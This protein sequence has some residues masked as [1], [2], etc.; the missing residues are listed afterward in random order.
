MKSFLMKNLILFLGC[1]LALSAWSKR[2]EWNGEYMHGGE[3]APVQ[4]LH[5]PVV[6]AGNEDGRQLIAKYRSDG[7]ACMHKMRQKYLCRK[8]IEPIL[9]DFIRDKFEGRIESYGSLIFGETRADDEI[10]IDGQT[11]KQWTVFQEI[12][13]GDLV[14][15]RYRY[16]ETQSLRKI[17]FGGKFAFSLKGDGFRWMQIFEKREMSY[18]AEADYLSVSE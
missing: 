1:T 16:T 3:I 11:V 10:R 2:P 5:R 4:T 17:E 12:R 8:F 9:P 13:F 7:Y 15:D 6:W 14:F 18:F